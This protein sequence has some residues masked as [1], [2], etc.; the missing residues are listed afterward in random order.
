MKYLK[1]Y[2]KSVRD[3]MTPKS[4]ED[5][6]DAYEEIANKVAEILV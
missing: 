1:S 5:I 2:N 4:E 6:D 3:K